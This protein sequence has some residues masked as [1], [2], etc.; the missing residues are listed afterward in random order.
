MKVWVVLAAD[1]EPWAVYSNEDAARTHL[2]ATEAT[3]RWTPAVETFEVEDSFT[4]LE[5]RGGLAF[6][7][8]PWVDGPD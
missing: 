2:E 1:M 3:G 5:D 6:G 7:D 8:R 4:D